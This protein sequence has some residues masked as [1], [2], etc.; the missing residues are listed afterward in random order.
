[1]LI[2]FDCTFAW[3]GGMSQDLGTNE[4]T[5]GLFVYSK[6]HK[7]WLQIQNTSTAG[8]KFGKT[9]STTFVQQPWDFTVLA[10][11]DFVPL[12]IPSLS[13]HYPDEVTFDEAQNT[14]VLH[15]DSF[16]TAE[17]ERTTL[18]IPKKDLTEAFD[19]Y[20]E[21]KFKRSGTD[22]RIETKNTPGY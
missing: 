1:L 2:S 21:P 18:L 11:N 14:Y 16:N 10:S 19:Y 8:A 13:P 7:R 9:S 4:N 5:L 20:A 6:T 22:H 17:S 3:I 12:P 15:F